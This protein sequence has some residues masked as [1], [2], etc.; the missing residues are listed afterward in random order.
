VSRLPV[1]V[2][3]PFVL[4]QA[5][6]VRESFIRLPDA[7]GAKDGLAAAPAGSASSGTAASGP[8]STGPASSGTAAGKPLRLLV[9]GDSTAVGTGVATLDDALPGRLAR[10]LAQQYSGGRSVAWRAVGQSGATST[11][12]LADF[13]DA[14]VAV[15]FDIAVVMVGWNDGLQV[16]STRAFVRSLGAL[17]TRLQNGS[18]DA[19]LVVVGPPDFAHFAI[20]PNPLRWALGRHTLGLAAAS[21]RVA[22]EHHAVASPGFDG[23]AVAAD[24]FHPNGAGYQGIAEGIAAALAATAAVPAANA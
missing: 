1:L 8:A 21:A 22:R 14:A 17:L 18:P 19:R 23:R 13:A 20:L 12:V 9:V 4:R 5:K 6:H 7:H 24:G 11:E 16:K 2:L 15:H 3:A 10:L